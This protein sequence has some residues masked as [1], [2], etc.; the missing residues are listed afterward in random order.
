MAS[1]RQVRGS[2]PCC[3]AA[4]RHA[5]PCRAALR[6]A[7]G[8]SSAWPSSRPS[9]C[10][11]GTA[12]PRLST[13]TT[14]QSSCVSDTVAQSVVAHTAWAAS[15]KVPQWPKWP[16]GSHPRGPGHATPRKCRSGAVPLW[17]SQ[18]PSGPV[19]H[20]AWARAWAK[21]RK[22]RS[23]PVAQCY[24]H[25]W[26]TMSRWQGPTCVRLCRDTLP[27]T[28]GVTILVTRTAFPLGPPLVK[29]NTALQLQGCLTEHP[30]P[31]CSLGAWARS[32]A[33]PRTRARVRAANSAKP[34]P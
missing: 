31:L 27:T 10:T 28:P 12:G 23:V 16:S 3:R 13:S 17:P 18:W 4:P 20:T 2:S 34:T 25:V 7:V 6:R 19:A 5:V 24:M 1:C 29:V 9:S 15:A 33:H 30:A 32:T 26:A 14:S 11:C 8:L 22:C 21:L